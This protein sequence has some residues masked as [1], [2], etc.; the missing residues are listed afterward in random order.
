MIFGRAKLTYNYFIMED[1]KRDI[2]H[3]LKKQGQ[4]SKRKELSQPKIK[5]DYNEYV[6]NTSPK[7]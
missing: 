1:L 2:D 4:S 3:L 7:T 5:C 6:D